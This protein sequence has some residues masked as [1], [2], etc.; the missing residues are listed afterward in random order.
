MA[1][2][3]G[4]L[5]KAALLAVCLVLSFAALAP[6]ATARPPAPPTDPPGVLNRERLNAVTDLAARLSRDR[7]WLT[8]T[9]LKSLAS[10]GLGL[11]EIFDG[12]PRYVAVDGAYYR[13][14]LEQV[15]H[16]WAGFNPDRDPFVVFLTHEV[17]DGLGEARALGY[18]GGEEMILYA[19]DFERF[20]AVAL[21]LFRLTQDEQRAV[22]GRPVNLAAKDR[23][24]LGK[25]RPAVAFRPDGPTGIKP[26]KKGKDYCPSEVAPTG[27]AGTQLLCPQNYQP[28]FVV[29]GLRVFDNHEGCCF[30]GDPEI[31]L[32]PLRID[33]VSGAGGTTN[34][35]T[36]F[37]LSGRNGVDIAGRVRYMPDVNDGGALIPMDLAV[38][39]AN[40]GS[41]FVVL[42][43]EDDN[44]PGVLILDNQSINVG[45]V[46]GAGFQIF[47]DIR[48]MDRF[49]LFK[50]S[51]SLLDLLGLLSNDD[52]L[53]QPSLGATN[54]FFCTNQL[55]GPFPN[56]ITRSSAEWEMQGYFACINPTCQDAPP[57]GGGGVEDPPPCQPEDLGCEPIIE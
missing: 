1:I 51:I 9:T 10:R 21:T 45:S 8:A 39:P 29:S 2:A 12:A 6:A 49:E 13:I 48:T 57:P 23:I 16:R 5:M 37:V 4:E 17:Y 7:G 33:S 27:C 55:G 46:I 18:Q 25:P 11:D 38:V 30:H 34:A 52:D 28:Y 35:T 31:E 36:P 43:V 47:Q 50:D 41:Q 24:D 14:K 15:G 42:M 26:V 54:S 3:K 44:Q 19:S 40:L 56:K 20:P 53:F 32:Y 22:R